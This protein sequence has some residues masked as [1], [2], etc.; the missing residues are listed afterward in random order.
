MAS[1][2]LFVKRSGIAGYRLFADEP[3]KKGEILM[4]WMCDANLLTEDEYNERQAKEDRQII[5]TGARYAGNLF[6]YTDSGPGKDRY[7]NY[8]NHSFDS[9]VL[10]HC[11]ICFAM[12]DIAVGEELTTDYTYILSENDK[13]SFHDAFTNKIVKGIPWLDC[14][15]DTTKKLTKIL[16]DI[17]ELPTLHDINL[18]CTKTD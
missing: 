17:K 16:D 4:F 2:K 7:E 11:G 9:N 10:Y 12:R 1:K 6:L 18:F 8:I 15:R 14:I 13:E 3:I 5:D